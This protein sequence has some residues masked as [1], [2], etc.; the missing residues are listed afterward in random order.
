MGQVDRD[1]A[2]IV[3][4][5]KIYFEMAKLFR[6]VDPRTGFGARSKH[7]LETL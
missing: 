3:V 7:D 5:G 1:L 4:G 2:N 6:D